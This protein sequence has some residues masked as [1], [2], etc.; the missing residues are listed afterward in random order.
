VCPTGI[1]IRNGIQMECIACTACI[2][3]CDEIMDKVGKPRGLIRYMPS[4]KTR[5][6]RFFR[7]RVQA[8]LAVLILLISGLLWALYQKPDIHVQVLRAT[9]VPYF[10][11]VEGD[12]EYIVNSYRLHV[13]NQKPDPITLKIS[14][15]GEFTHKSNWKLQVPPSL[16]TFKSKDFKMIPFLIEIPKS[17]LPKDGKLKLQIHVNN[18]IKEISFVGP[19]Q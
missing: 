2:D 13:Q 15:A 8:Y 18:Q 3:A 17:D 9:D 19:N 6:V 10:Q 12:V 16:L 1:D 7:P 4:T 5:R 11:K 14:F